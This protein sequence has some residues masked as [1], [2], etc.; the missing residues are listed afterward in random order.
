MTSER[1]SDVRDLTDRGYTPSVGQHIVY[2]CTVCG[3]NNGPRMLA[4]RKIPGINLNVHCTPCG[5]TANLDERVR[6]LLPEAVSI[7]GTFDRWIEDR[8]A[9]QRAALRAVIRAVLEAEAARVKA[10]GGKA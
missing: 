3:G 9:A 8:N 10:K 6:Q 2:R 5:T 7:V 4:G 1:L